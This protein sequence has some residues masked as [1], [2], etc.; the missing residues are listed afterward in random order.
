MKLTDREKIFLL[1][2]VRETVRN[3]INSSGLRYEP[4]LQNIISLNRPE[5]LENHSAHVTIY[6]DNKVLVSVGRLNPNYPLYLLVRDLSIEATKRASI[7]FSD[8]NNIICEVSVLQPPTKINSPDEIRLGFHG[9]HLIKEDRYGTLLPN[10]YGFKGWSK[11]EM[12]E[13]C[14]TDKLKLENPNDWMNCELYVFEDIS[15]NEKQ[16]NLL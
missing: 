1:E 7:N 15:F 16:F 12:V 11:Y 10:T 5:V 8:F 6:K 3:C 13:H 9:I 2:I 14:A 4:S